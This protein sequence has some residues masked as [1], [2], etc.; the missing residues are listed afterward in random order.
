MIRIFILPLLFSPCFLFAQTTE[1]AMKGGQIFGKA[2]FI[3]K[4]I[5]L[6][7]EEN[8]APSGVT[9]ALHVSAH[10][11]K[12]LRLGTEFGLNSFD[13]IVDQE[14]IPSS[15]GSK[16]Q[17][18][19]RHNINQFYLTVVPEYRFPKGRFLF[20]NAGA[21]IFKDYT[22]SFDGMFFN[23]SGIESVF[24]NFFDRRLNRGFFVGAGLCPQLSKNFGFLLEMRYTDL[25]A[26]QD[27]YLRLRYKL[28]TVNVGLSYLIGGRP[29]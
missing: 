20:I 15:G 9:A 2:A 29:W 18:L 6:L 28:L 11:I 1:I 21:G 22:A 26:V 27:G 17:Y 8:G 16:L 4:D 10:L 7:S 23:T 25:P 19:G 24:G 13:N 14:F 12:G 3:G 5:S